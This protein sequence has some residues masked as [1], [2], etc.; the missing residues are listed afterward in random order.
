MATSNFHFCWFF[1]QVS[2]VAVEWSG[3]SL[4]QRSTEGAAN[5]KWPEMLQC[6]PE[7]HEWSRHGWACTGLG[8]GTEEEQRTLWGVW[9]LLS[10]ARCLLRTPVWQARASCPVVL[11]PPP[12]LSQKC[13]DYIC[14]SCLR[15]T[16]SVPS[17]QT[18][19]EVPLSAEFFHTLQRQ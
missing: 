7:L 11:V 13:W 3:P 15:L 2:V 19:Q 8:E 18:W 12:I 5:E 6:H 14:A 10:P 17:L 4:S 1:S 16:E 9:P